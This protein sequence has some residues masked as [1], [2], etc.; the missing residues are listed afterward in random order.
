MANKTKLNGPAPFSVSQHVRRE[1]ARFRPASLSLLA[2]STAFSA[3]AVGQ[4]APPKTDT[5]SV[6]DGPEE[7]VVNGYKKSL[8]IA[9]NIKKDS[10]IVKDVIVAEDMAKF[11][12]LNLA[13]SIQRIPGVAITRE[14][15]EGR[16]IS[17]RGLGP[18]FSRVQ[19]NGMEVLGNNDSAMD[20]RG[21]RSRDRA[22]DFNLFASELFSRVEVEKTYQAAQN[23]GGMAGTVGL[24]TGKPFDYADGFKG[25]ISAKGGTNTYT[26][27]FQPRVAGLASYNWD[28]TF[29]VLVSAAWSRRKTQEQGFNTYNYNHPGADDMASAVAADPGLI[30]SLTP[31]QQAKFLSGDLYF[32]DGN[33]LSVWD[34]DQTRLGLTASVQW[35]PAD[36]LL[37]TVDGLHGR[38]TTLRDEYHL[39]TR[40]FNGAGSGAWDYGTI[41]PS[42]WPNTINLNSTINSINYDSTGFVNSIN[43]S[44][45]TFGSEHRR[46]RNENRFNMAELTGKWDV[47]DAFTVDGH[48]GLQT[49]TYHTPYDDKLYMRGQGAF[50]ST[51]SAD[52]KSASNVY[53]WDTTNPNNYFMDDFYFRG[54]Y[55]DTTERE[56]VLNLKYKFSDEYDVRA[57]YAFHRYW[58]A[59][60]NWFDDG[61][62]NGTDDPTSP[63]YTRGAPVA[64]F[65]RTFCE[66][67]QSCWLTGNY[68]RAFQYFNIAFQSSAYYQAQAF[69]IEN[70]FE[71]VE[72]TSDGFVQFD[73]NKQLPAGMRLRGNVGAR[74]YHTN[75]SSTGWI[76]GNNYAYEG[77]QTVGDSYSG[78]LP[79]LNAVLEI[80]PETLVRFAATQNLNRPTIS[81]LAAQGGVTRNDDG[82]FDISFGNPKLKP[83]KDT[84]V[85]LSGEYYFGKTG[86]LSLGVFHKDIKNWIGSFQQQNV[87]YSATGLTLTPQLASIYPDLTESSLVKSYSYPINVDKVKLTGVESAVQLPFYF[88]PAPFNGF[89]VLGNI[90]YVHGSKEITGLSKLTANATLYYET[91]L[92]GVRGSLSHRSSYQT[93]PLDSDPIDGVGYFGTTYVDAAAFVN[94]APGL[95]VTVDAIN[96]TNEAEIENYS[97][98]YRLYNKTQSGTTVFLGVVY[99]Y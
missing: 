62:Q 31:A 35:K 30:S 4:T 96:I 15:G 14:A 38:Y 64:A 48:V 60:Q 82:T 79:A 58:S 47:T 8:E 74:F 17:L 80:T 54:F 25:A 27:D 67:K 41:G 86:L 56:A 44:N 85:D 94:V 66:N 39:A 36:N 81:S 55:N 72:N 28:N 69:D 73:W 5:T 57:G 77:S 68:D 98:Y 50:T 9:I 75:T 88:L 37:F 13:E 45:A 52:G 95:Q 24:F 65:T 97:S 51:Y 63:L 21:Q 84:T 49:S 32:P 91:S 3:L 40:P 71:V 10:D 90:A 83:F 20:S 1:L 70:T 11:P 87:P 76:Q 33:R 99:K 34:S 26:E 78:V 92:F 23:E 18:D 29:G 93:S 22:F 42:D 53:S 19:L 61:N 89:G 59:G 12:E 16:E 43:V 6:S 7:V 2:L 46:E